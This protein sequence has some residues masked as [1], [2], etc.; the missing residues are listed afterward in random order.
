MGGKD[1]D[2]KTRVFDKTVI[3][4]T[5]PVFVCSERRDWRR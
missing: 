4:I 3:K 5:R 1:P 2:A